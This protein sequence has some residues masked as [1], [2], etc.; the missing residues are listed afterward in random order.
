MNITCNWWKTYKSLRILF[1]R[2]TK[3]TA[4]RYFWNNFRSFY[5]KKKKNFYTM[6][7]NKYYYVCI[8]RGILS[9]KQKIWRVKN[10]RETKLII[11]FFF[12][13]KRN[14]EVYKNIFI[15]PTHLLNIL[16]LDRMRA[17]VYQTFTPYARTHTNFF[18]Y[19]AEITSATSF[20]SIRESRIPRKQRRGE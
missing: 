5:K 3:T 13:S 18:M 9:T 1:S 19:S 10:S 14:D 6:N 11:I 2:R 16:R 8:S 12:C 4:E 20:R 7:A 15:A 17:H